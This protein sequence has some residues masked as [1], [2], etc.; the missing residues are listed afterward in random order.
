VD[1]PAAVTRQYGM[2]PRMSL[3]AV[4]VLGR[5]RP[6][7][8]AET[9]AALAGLGNLEDST[10]TLLRGSF[11][12]VLL[13]QTSASRPD[14]E[15]AL[16]QLASD[17]RL[18]VDVREVPPPQPQ[19]PEG[20][21]VPYVLSVHGADRPGIVSAITAEVASAG[22]NITDLTTRLAGELYVLIAEVHVPTGAD[23]GELAERI[24]RTAE[25]L[26]VDASLRPLET[27]EL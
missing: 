5:D 8:V 27:D 17:G 2:M 13:V 23:V 24:A 21:A 20:S 1:R 12:M 18:T 7:I 14:V 4:T 26:G 22:G 16:A 25:S 11:A 6:G 3:L 9:T 10:M 15:S 19:A